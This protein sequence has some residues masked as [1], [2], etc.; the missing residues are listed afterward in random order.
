MKHFLTKYFINA[1]YLMKIIMQK[2]LLPRNSSFQMELD[3]DAYSDL[4]DKII[5]KSR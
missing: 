1:T 5:S 3:K 4:R 2:F